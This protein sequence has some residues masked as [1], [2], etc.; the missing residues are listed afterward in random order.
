[1]VQRLFELFSVESSPN[2]SEHQ[3]LLRHSDKL[4]GT[5]FEQSILLTPCRVLQTL[6]RPTSTSRSAEAAANIA[7]MRT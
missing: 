7:A 4:R 6:E 3:P 5:Q 1:M 2:D